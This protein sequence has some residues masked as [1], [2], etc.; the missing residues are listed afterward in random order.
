MAWVLATTSL[1]R[2]AFSCSYLYYFEYNQPVI[3]V[4]TLTCRHSFRVHEIKI[5]QMHHLIQQ[6]T[7]CIHSDLPGFEIL[8]LFLTEPFNILSN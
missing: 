1:L 7:K 3:L 4:L 2:W 5:L 8:V 6:N